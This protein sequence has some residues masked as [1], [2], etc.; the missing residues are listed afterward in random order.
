MIFYDDIAND[1]LMFFPYSKILYTYSYRHVAVS[2]E[3][4][5]RMAG[6]TFCILAL[7]PVSFFLIIFLMFHPPGP[8]SPRTSSKCSKS[9][10]L[11]D[12]CSCVAP[13]TWTTMD[14]SYSTF[15]TNSI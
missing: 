12:S 4:T 1:V 15:I 5:Y 13:T 14:L 8:V 6:L 11:Q 9:P 3:R 7:H 10:R 2:N